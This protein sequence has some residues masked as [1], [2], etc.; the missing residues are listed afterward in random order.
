VE[1]EAG[2]YTT[3]GGKEVCKHSRHHQMS[4]PLIRVRNNRRF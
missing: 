4:E 3:H 1:L 2:A